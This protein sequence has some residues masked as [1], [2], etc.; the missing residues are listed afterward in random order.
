MKFEVS[1]KQFRDAFTQ[2]GRVVPAN[3]PKP[4]LKCVLMQADGDSVKLIA[5]DMNVQIEVPVSGVTVREPGRVLLP[6]DVTDRILK[7]SDTDN[8]A[9]STAGNSIEVET[10][11]TTGKRRSAKWSAQIEDPD[12]F[13]VRDTDSIGFL[14]SVT[15]ND[16]KTSIPRVAACCD[17]RSGG[18]MSGVLIES[19]GDNQ[20]RFVGTDSHRMGI[21]TLPMSM[22]LTDAIPERPVIPAALLRTAVGC[23]PTGESLVSIGFAGKTAIAFNFGN[24]IVLS[25]QLLDGRFCNYKMLL[26]SIGVGG[27][28]TVST[29]E[30]LAS[31]E[32]ASVASDKMS[33]GASFAFGDK[34][35]RITREVEGSRA[36]VDCE[37]VYGG[38][39]V[40]ALYDPALIPT[41]VFRGIDSD[42]KW[43]G[44]DAKLPSRIDVESAGLIY[45]IVP[46][47]KVK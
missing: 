1:A 34:L 38:S 46:M 5:T 27:K 11:G 39:P 37:I 41:D 14:F 33:S 47:E 13:P 44:I 2:A 21:V 6:K 40:T 15:G 26:E 25:G 32:A 45:L 17:V 8:L 19:I 4:V 36:E 18:W 30:L 35:L 3:T 7:A 43:T 42:V 22:I 28:A 31:I 12:L 20:I 29:P 10:F 16:F 24:D 9:F 23:I